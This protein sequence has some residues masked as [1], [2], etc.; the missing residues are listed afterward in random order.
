MLFKEKT[1]SQPHRSLTV[2]QLRENFRMQID[3]GI[4]CVYCNYVEQDVQTSVN[5]LASIWR[6]LVYDRDSLSSD[7]EELYKLLR[8]QSTIPTLKDITKSFGLRLVGTLRF[9]LS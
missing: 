1:V 7:V 2:Q 5:L 8:R 4:A 3:V 9:L 6:Q